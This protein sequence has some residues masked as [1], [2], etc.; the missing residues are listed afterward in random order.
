MQARGVEGNV[1]SPLMRDNP[2]AMAYVKLEPNEYFDVRRFGTLPSHGQQSRTI[3]GETSCATVHK[4]WQLRQKEEKM[5]VEYAK[6]AM[7]MSILRDAL[8]AVCVSKLARLARDIEAA[9]H[10]ND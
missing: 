10:P 2:D 3:Y 9:W 7:N 6:E 8:K 5:V 4:A 1:V